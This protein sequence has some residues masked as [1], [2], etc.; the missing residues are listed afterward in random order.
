MEI[1]NTIQKYQELVA[2]T[3]E[4]LA[5]LSVSVAQMLALEMQRELAELDGPEISMAHRQMLQQMCL[6]PNRISD[7]AA[8]NGITKQGVSKL[9]N[10]LERDG[11]VASIVD[12]TDARARVVEHTSK[13]LEVLELMITATRKI[14]A[15]LAD[16][17][18]STQLREMKKLLS[19]LLD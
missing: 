7:L 15:R 13:G 16:K 1:E 3:G 6:G 17:I 18:G 9:M 10:A 8:R 19:E 12:E 2:E 4:P 11:Y 5:R 14:E